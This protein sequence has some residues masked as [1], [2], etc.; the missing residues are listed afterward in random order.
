MIIES[1]A[2]KGWRNYREERAKFSPGINLFL[3][4]NGQGKTNFLEAIY[5]LSCGQSPRVAKIEELI[6]WQE[7]YFYLKGEI[8]RGGQRAVIEM[9]GARDG[10]RINKIDGVPLDRL[11]E[12]SG[13][14]N[15]V[16]FMPEDLYLVKGGPNVRR[17]F[18]DVEIAKVSRNYH[19]TLRKYKKFLQQRNAHLKSGLK[20][21]ILLQ[22]L[23]EK[24]AI[25][26]G[27]IG[28]QRQNYLQKLSV[29]A[30]L[31]YRKLC[32]T[33]GD[34]NLQYNW[35]I[36]P[37]LPQQKVLEKYLETTSLEQRYRSTILGPHKDDFVFLID[38][39]DL[40]VFGSQGQQRTAVLAVKLAEIDLI[41]AETGESPVLLLDDVFSELDEERKKML[42]A[43]LA[44]GVQTFI[45]SAEP[46]PT[47]EVVHEHW[48]DSGR[49]RE[50]I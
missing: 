46:L 1:L 49:I 15:A 22:V 8:S 23:T 39:K 16:F 29:L 35:S 18:L 32:S 50:R 11:A 34:L 43:Y 17:G 2:V 4:K 14:L 13:L 40:K 48:I 30:R 44:K 37:G 6:H 27:P 45:S 9:G 28:E 47:G 7:R 24:L 19:Y 26:A 36:E 20:D 5:F 41:A 10:R 21:K 31:K 12:I 42:L 3:G 33:D 38:G 25:L